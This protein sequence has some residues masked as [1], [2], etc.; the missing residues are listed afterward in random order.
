LEVGGRG[1]EDGDVDVGDGGET[2]G[3]LKG[4]GGVNYLNLGHCDGVGRAGGPWYGGNWRDCIETWV[5]G[6][7]RSPETVED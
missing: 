3:E 1:L 2:D 4:C 7:L 5:Y 6:A